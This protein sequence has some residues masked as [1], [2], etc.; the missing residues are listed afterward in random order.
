MYILSIFIL[1][2]PSTSMWILFLS[3]IPKIVADFGHE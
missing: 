2:F 3:P 1:A